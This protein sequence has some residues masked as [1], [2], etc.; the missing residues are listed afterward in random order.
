MRVADGERYS[1]GGA[2]LEFRHASGRTPESMS[3]VVY[4][5]ADD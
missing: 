3:T 2:T 1:L 4:E 5:H